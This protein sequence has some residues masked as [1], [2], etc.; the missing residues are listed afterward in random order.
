MKRIEDIEKMDPE[1]LEQAALEEV[2]TVPEGLRDRIETALAAKAVMD[3]TSGESAVNNS[4]APAEPVGISMNQATNAPRRQRWIPVSAIAAAAA[5]A[6]LFMIPRLNDRSLQDTYNDPALA[7]AQVEAT[8]RQ[9]SDKMT[10]GVNKA[11]KAVETAEKPKQI[12]K[13]I[14]E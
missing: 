3:S 6:A 8:F 14:N 11:S 2:A 9:I 12:I 1:A 5:I 7:Y 10:I 13:K 4:G